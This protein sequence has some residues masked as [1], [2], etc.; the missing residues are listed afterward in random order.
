MPN[1]SQ[2]KRS[3]TELESD[4][5]HLNEDM[6]KEILNTVKSNKTQ[7]NDLAIKLDNF[8]SRYNDLSIKYEDLE[9]KYSDLNVK[10]EELVSDNIDLHNKYTS[11]NK[12]IDRINQQSLNSN[13]EIAGVP[14]LESESPTEI[15]STIF[16]KLGFL[17]E[18]II[19]SAYRRNS[20]N[21]ISG[22][23]KNIIVSIVDKGQRDRILAA[24]RKIK[25]L[26]TSILEDNYNLI[27]KQKS[28]PQ[29][30]GSN[31][32]PNKDINTRPIYLNEHLTDFNKYL[33][34][35]SKNLRRSGKVFMAYARNGFVIVRV[36]AN[37]PEIRIESV[38]QLDDIHDEHNKSSQPK[39][40]F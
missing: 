5:E 12:S 34:A 30:S 29:S 15:A 40:T 6:L 9:N 28:D 16:K 18:K 32:Q 7:L 38:A 20:K 8:E 26:N 10:Y 39:A 17:D 35:R 19:R 11:V 25:N 14:D 3:R 21:I 33:L 37:S 4:T 1:E 31:S 23:P 36:E 2:T 27:Q 22:L 13:I 24:S